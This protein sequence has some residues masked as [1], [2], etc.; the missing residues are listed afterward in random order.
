[1]A[2]ALGE[3]VSYLLALARGEVELW[4]EKADGV[5]TE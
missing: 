2:E 1:M 5:T 4:Q 3:E